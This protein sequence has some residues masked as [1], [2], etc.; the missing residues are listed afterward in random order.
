M[1]VIEILIDFIRSF[2][3]KKIV[4][5]L[6]LLIMLF[7]FEIPCFAA[8]DYLG[9]TFF[10]TA[11]KDSV[12]FIQA[13]PNGDIYV[14]G[15]IGDLSLQNVAGFDT[16]YTSSADKLAYIARFD[17]NL[18]TLKAFTYIG[19]SYSY[20]F[21]FKVAPDGDVYIVTFPFDLDLPDTIPE[22]NTVYRNSYNMIIRFDANLESIKGYTYLYD[23]ADIS[24]F[25]LNSSGD[26]VIAGDKFISYNDN[27]YNTDAFIGILNS[28]LTLL[29]QSYT[30]GGSHVDSID[31]VYIDS[32]GNIFASG[33]TLSSDFIDSQNKCLTGEDCSGAFTNKLFATEFDSSLN[34]I[35]TAIIAN[36]YPS[37][38]ITG[39]SNNIYIAARTDSTLFVENNTPDNYHPVILKLDR[40][41]ASIEKSFVMN[42][43][44]GDYIQSLISFDSRI[45]IGGAIF[46]TGNAAFPFT[47]GAWRPESS[48]YSVGMVMVL[49]NDLSSID[50]ATIIGGDF[51]ADTVQ[52]VCFSDNTLYAGGY[53][54]SA[55]FP[56]G[57]SAYQTSCTRGI[58]GSCYDGFIARFSPF[59]ATS[60]IT[61]L[62]VDITGSH[63]K[64]SWDNTGNYNG[65]TLYYTGYPYTGS[66]IIHTIDLGG[67]NSIEF[68]LWSG[69]GFYVAIM[70][71]NDSNEQ[72]SI[73]NV[74]LIQIP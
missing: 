62:S 3:E 14:S 17:K 5:I 18:E 67:T 38:I 33:C 7:C 13:G 57:E 61:S 65:Y 53:A 29:K 55:N 19:D 52:S 56:A 45:F 47:E 2:H 44:Q 69:A 23:I 21:S 35:K 42:Y 31:S 11:G 59:E 40:D 50:Y 66:E 46:N 22:L 4:F 8:S 10:G 6:L 72:G 70:P 60:D 68:D 1:A 16:D 20:P 43:S 24:T 28:D 51:A 58:G 12:N 74:Q 49:E 9:S 34:L 30:Y 39:D 41:L 37:D 64:M 48:S 71:Y 63:V 27:V 15:V 25:E 26:L 73:S 54:Q 32:E 36:A